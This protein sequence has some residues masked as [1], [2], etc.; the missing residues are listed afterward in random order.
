M[1]PSSS[2]YYSHAATRTVTDID[3]R[4]DKK[5]AAVKSYLNSKRSPSGSGEKD[6][7]K[8]DSILRRADSTLRIE[9]GIDLWLRDANPGLPTK[10]GSEWEFMPMRNWVLHATRA[11]TFDP[12]SDFHATEDMSDEDRKYCSFILFGMTSDLFFIDDRSGSR[13][14][15]LAVHVYSSCPCVASTNCV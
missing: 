10:G 1:L 2:Y 8:D 9:E 15:V 4:D 5:L 7:V 12:P 6:N 3:L 11:V 14:S 13:E